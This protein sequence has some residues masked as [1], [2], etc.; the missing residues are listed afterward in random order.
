M[1]DINIEE[2]L[3]HSAPFILP[4]RVLA[5][6]NEQF[7]HTQKS[8]EVGD[9]FLNG[10]FASQPVFPGVMLIETMAQSAGLLL[11]FLFN[12]Q[13]LIYL[14][15]VNNVRFKQVVEPPSMLDVKVQLEKSRRSV[16]FFSGQI[17][18]DAQEVA[19]AEF[20]LALGDPV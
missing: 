6:D 2:A 15:R 17:F 13:V 8:L 18:V 16:W 9:Y 7:I 14:A 10:H 4:D 11:Y 3:P 5:C 1:I 12:Q 19:S 20:A